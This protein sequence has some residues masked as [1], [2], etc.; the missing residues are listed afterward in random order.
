MQA[1]YHTRDSLHVRLSAQK[2]RPS[3]PVSLHRIG[4]ITHD[5]AL[6][7][8]ICV[9]CKKRRRRRHPP[10]PSLTLSTKHPHRQFLQSQAPH[11][12][13]SHHPLPPQ[14]PLHSWSHHSIPYRLLFP[15][16]YPHHGI[17]SPQIHIIPI[18][19]HLALCPPN[20][21][22]GHG[23]RSRLQTVIASLLPIHHTRARILS[24]T[25]LHQNIL[26]PILYT[27]G[28]TSNTKFYPLI[29]QLL[30]PRCRS[31]TDRTDWRKLR[32][33][34]LS[35]SSL[36]CSSTSCTP[37]LPAS[38][39]HHSWQIFTHEGKNVTHSSSPW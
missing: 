25:P 17:P 36:P 12:V 3:K 32:P 15:F 33:V 10:N 2:K 6:D 39:S 34:I 7:Q 29:Q 23:R 37:S 35:P 8:D 4:F 9:V 16:L 21:L 1:L 19:R 20:P 30:F 38:I 5:N 27:T 28:H 31:T 13:S 11:R 18:I 22:M 26:V 24:H 14:A